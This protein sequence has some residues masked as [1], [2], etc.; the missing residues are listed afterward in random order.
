M[1]RKPK[2]KKRG[3]LPSYWVNLDEV[4][5]IFLELLSKKK[6]TDYGK[7]K[8]DGIILDVIQDV[9]KQEIIW[10]VTEDLIALTGIEFLPNDCRNIGYL[11]SFDMYIDDEL[12]FENIYIKEVEEYKHF[13]IRKPLKKG[14]T[15]KFIFNNNDNMLEY[16]MFNI[17]YIGDIKV[18][19]YNIIC[20][21]ID[22]NAII[23]QK[24][25]FLVE[26]FEEQEVCPTEIE[27]YTKISEDCVIVNQETTN[28]EIVFYYKKEELPILHQYD[29]LC[30]LY[31][32]S[33][34][35][36][37]LHCLIDGQEEVS[38]KNKELLIDNNN[39]CWLD[40]DYIKWNNEPEVITILGFTD[41]KALLKINHYS[42]NLSDNEKIRVE[43]YKKGTDKMDIL[44]R[45]FSI[46]GANL[47]HKTPVNVCEIDL[48]T[49]KV[50]KL[51]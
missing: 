51:I 14:S 29:I 7:Q 30:K 26:P 43:I 17:H 20:K 23:Q 12:Y 31:W 18:K 50:I 34:I 9:S 49:Q 36:L 44:L 27:G 33:S 13:N 45:E 39:G 47:S 6:Y 8:V 35:D 1:N 25:L 37:D 2:E 11:N 3:M 19:K 15:I 21:D 48:K 42:G 24:E 16:L 4:A 46:L 28:E 40:Y 5:Q 22:T 41:K 32:E 38:F 10:N